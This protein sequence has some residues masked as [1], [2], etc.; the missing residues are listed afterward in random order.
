MNLKSL[1]VC[2]RSQKQQWEVADKDFDY[3]EKHTVQW[4]RDVWGNQESS[5]IINSKYKNPFH[6]LFVYYLAY[7]LKKDR[8]LPSIWD[9]IDQIKETGR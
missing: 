3:P 2:Q 9:A 5:Q 7:N 6:S 8:R 4:C 1:T